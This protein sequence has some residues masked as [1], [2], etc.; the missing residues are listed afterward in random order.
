MIIDTQSKLTYSLTSL[1]DGDNSKQLLNS[2]T[3]AKTYRPSL[4]LDI[5]T[6]RRL[7]SLK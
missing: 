6:T 7:T 3:L 5:A 2:D 1:N 4:A